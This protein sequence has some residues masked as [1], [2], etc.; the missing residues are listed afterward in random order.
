MPPA[1]RDDDGRLH[2][3][4]QPSSN[5]M[6]NMR[7]AT[8]MV[9]YAG[10]EELWGLLVATTKTQ[11]LVMLDE[12]DDPSAFRV[13]ALM[14]DETGP[15]GGCWL[16]VTGETHENLDAANMDKNR[17]WYEPHELPENEFWPF[18]EA[19]ADDEKS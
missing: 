6:E 11:L 5:Q 2:R 13:S 10:K 1:W 12:L 14:P 18:D 4:P 3:R 15:F 9:R 8:F 7:M 17:E 19:E 16:Q